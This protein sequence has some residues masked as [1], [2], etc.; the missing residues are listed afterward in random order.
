M[1]G[2]NPKILTSTKPVRCSFNE[3][4]PVLRRFIEGESSFSNSQTSQQ[5]VDRYILHLQDLMH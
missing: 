5:Q 1:S 2:F 4:G 3:V